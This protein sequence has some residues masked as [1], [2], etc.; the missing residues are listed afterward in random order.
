MGPISVGER[1]KQALNT[2]SAKS[3]VSVFP[4]Y[5]MLWTLSKRE[6]VQSADAG[7]SSSILQRVLVYRQYRIPAPAKRT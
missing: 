5:V 2:T 7:Q 4:D 6:V 3:I 1:Q